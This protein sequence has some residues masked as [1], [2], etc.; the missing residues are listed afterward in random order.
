VIY[1]V[2]GHGDDDMAFEE[3]I[4]EKDVCIMAMDVTCF[5]VDQ[6]LLIVLMITF[7]DGFYD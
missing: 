3:Q 5:I 7:H 2:V 6:L 1:W 4:Y